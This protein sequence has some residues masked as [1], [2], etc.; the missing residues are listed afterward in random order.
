MNNNAGLMAIN[1]LSL[2]VFPL[3]LRSANQAAI[4]QKGGNMRRF[5]SV[6]PLIVLP[7]IL[8]MQPLSMVRIG[9]SLP[10]TRF[11]K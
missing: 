8:V 6:F 5:I 7:L 1:S 4:Q 3:G 11:S 10:A 2:F 9:K